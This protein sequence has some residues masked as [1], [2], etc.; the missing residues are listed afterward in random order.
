[1]TAGLAFWLSTKTDAPLGAVGGAVGLTALADGR[2]VSVLESGVRAPFSSLE[3]PGATDDEIRDLA[4]RDRRAGFDLATGPLM[5]YT[6]VRTGPARHVLV[7]TVHHVIADGWSVPPM[8]RAL[9]AEYHA[10]DTVYAPGG[11]PDYL[12]WLAERDADESDRVWRGELAELPGPSLVAEGHTPSDRF[13]DT[14]VTDDN[15]TDAAVRSAGVPLSVAV[16]SAWALTLGGLLHGTDVVFGS[17]VSG[18]DAEVPGIGDMVGLF[19]N[20]IPVRARWTGTTTAGDLLAAVREH[21]SAVLPHQHVSLAR[22]G[23]QAGVGA[24]FDTLVVFDVATDPGALR[25]PGDT[26]VIADITNEGAPHYPL[27]LVV[28]RAST[29][30]AQLQPVRVL[31]SGQECQP[32]RPQ[33]RR[34]RT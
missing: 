2:V 8:L 29:A 18:R 24:L 27:T 25:G 23:R 3:R 22:I 14:A 34:T 13:A 20:T 7:Q 17:T 19:I 28:E 30:S 26:L 11:F 5:R 15:D 12:H 31:P 6:L 33:S 32:L 16:H 9:L 10:P 1:V 21:Q 4:E